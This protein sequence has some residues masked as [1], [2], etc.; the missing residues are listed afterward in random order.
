MP[1]Q[2]SHV[3]K[4]GNRQTLK[5]QLP[6]KKMASMFE[7]WACVFLINASDNVFTQDR[8]T[9]ASSHWQ[10]HNKD[11]L[12]ETKYESKPLES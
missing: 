11:S 5:K 3:A 10:W 1:S 9:T 6:K 4:L 12:S 2:Y 8:L 7:E